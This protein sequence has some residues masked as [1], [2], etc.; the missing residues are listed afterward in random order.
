MS[1]TALLQPLHLDHVEGR[2][3]LLGQKMNDVAERKATL[4]DDTEKQT[5]LVWMTH[6]LLDL[7]WVDF[8]LGL[9]QYA[10]F[11]ASGGVP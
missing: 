9:P 7:G 1:R 5:R 11:S 6:L 8:D 4:L 10:V 2:L 3:A